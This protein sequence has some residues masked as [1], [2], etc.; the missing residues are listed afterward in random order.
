MSLTNEVLDVVSLLVFGFVRLHVG[1]MLRKPKG[2]LKI[3][4]YMLQIK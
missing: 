1:S 3:V 4:P 2:K